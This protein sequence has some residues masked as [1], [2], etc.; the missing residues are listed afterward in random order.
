MSR[1]EVCQIFRN[2]W[3][4]A[5]HLGLDISLTLLRSKHLV[6]FD[7]TRKTEINMFSCAHGPLGFAYPHRTLLQLYFWPVLKQ[8]GNPKKTAFAKKGW[9]T[10]SESWI[11][12][13]SPCLPSVRRH[14]FVI[15]AL[16]LPFYRTFISI[17]NIQKY[18]YKYPPKGGTLRVVHWLTETTSKAWHLSAIVV[19]VMPRV[20]SY[21]SYSYSYSSYYSSYYYYYYKHS[22]DTLT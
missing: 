9:H 18:V 19:V 5:S 15:L 13:S 12:Y 21:Y 7:G 20:T 14:N 22:G 6:A 3:T 4:R 17:I 1:Q 10:S 8:A 2:S 11:S 16:S